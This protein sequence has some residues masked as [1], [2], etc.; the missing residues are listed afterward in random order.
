M[1]ICQYLK[2]E[3]DF[4]CNEEEM[5]YLILHVNRLCVREDCYRKSITSPE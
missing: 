3:L 2:E 4:E 5:L 1:L